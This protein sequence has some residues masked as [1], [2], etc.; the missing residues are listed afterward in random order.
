MKRCYLYIILCLL[1]WGCRN[2]WT[3]NEFTVLSEMI[4]D[5]KFPGEKI[6]F[7]K[8]ERMEFMIINF[9]RDEMVLDCNS[10][11]VVELRA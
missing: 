9:L 7:V 11:F 5:S 8:R 6:S 3:E 4:D 10:F 2:E 1:G